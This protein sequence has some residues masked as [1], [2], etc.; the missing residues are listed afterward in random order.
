VARILLFFLSKEKNLN[1][2]GTDMKKIFIGLIMAVTLTL[3]FTI[4]GAGKYLSSDLRPS[5]TIEKAFASESLPNAMTRA[6]QPARNASSFSW[7]T[8]VYLYTMMAVA[9]AVRRNTNA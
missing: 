1:A 9:V 7:P 2:R 3:V 4:D 8:I 6:Q 5:I